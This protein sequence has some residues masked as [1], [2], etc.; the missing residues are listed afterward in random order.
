LIDG[1]SVEKKTLPD[2][3]SLLRG[4]ADVPVLLSILRPATAQT[5]DIKVIRKKIEIESVQDI[6]IVGKA[7]GYMR[8]AEFS[9]KT[10]DQFERGL[11]SLH[12]NGMK[13]LIIDLRDNDGGVMPAAV[14]IA[15]L[16]LTKGTK[17]VSLS[18]KIEVQRKEFVSGRDQ[19]EPFYPTVILVNERSASASEIFAA[20]MQ[21]HKRAVLVGQKTFGKASVQSV[22]PLDTETAMKLTTARYVSPSGRIIDGQGIMPDEVIE[23]GPPGQ[24]GSDLQIVRAL[25]LLK[26]YYE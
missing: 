11:R 6:R 16:F 1:R 14:A 15:E 9:D 3:S 8:I 24:P 26:D 4:D 2:I 23:N 5:L 7:V 22:I 21:D 18:S 10:A 19:A 25:I 20:A 17:I 12:K 13:A